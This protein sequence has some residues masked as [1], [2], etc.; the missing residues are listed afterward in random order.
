MKRCGA[1]SF[2]SWRR[3]TPP[4]PRGGEGVTVL[5]APP[6][7]APPATDAATL[8]ALLVEALARRS[9]SGAAAEVA[10]RTGADRRALY[11]RAVSL[12]RAAGDKRG[13]GA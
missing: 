7:K 11:D 4:P 3:T 13:S 9:P 5:V 8:D 2:P 12:K 10:A 6:G 1:A